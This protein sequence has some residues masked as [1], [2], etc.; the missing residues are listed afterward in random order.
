[1]YQIILTRIPGTLAVGLQDMVEY[2][3]QYCDQQDGDLRGVHSTSLYSKSSPCPYR[4][5]L[6]TAFEERQVDPCVP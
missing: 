3:H 5:V 6:W 4:N 2:C 1:M